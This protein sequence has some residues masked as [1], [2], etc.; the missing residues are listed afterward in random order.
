M[1]NRTSHSPQKQVAVVSRLAK[2]LGL[3]IQNDYEKQCL[4]NPNLTSKL[5]EAVK[6]F[7]F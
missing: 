4:G 6:E 3:S 1:L 7:F 5:K 2:E